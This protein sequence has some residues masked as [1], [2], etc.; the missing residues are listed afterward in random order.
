M[1]LFVKYWI[2]V[3][4]EYNAYVIDFKKTVFNPY[5]LF[6]FV[7][8]LRQPVVRSPIPVRNGKIHWHR[9]TDMK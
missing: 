6:Q 1:S 5:H 2:I 9:K 8:S 4:T 7:R 3:I